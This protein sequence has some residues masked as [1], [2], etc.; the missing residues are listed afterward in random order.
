MDVFSFCGDII[1]EYE[2]FSRSFTRIRAKDISQA[3]DESYKD[4]QFWPEPL[5]QLNPNFVTGG[6]IDDLVS[7]GTLDAECKKIFRINK[8]TDT[9]G[10]L[11]VLHKHQAKPYT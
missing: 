9:N 5:I 6:S 2:G 11:L 8:T 7:E 4:R 10:E 1:A 3:I